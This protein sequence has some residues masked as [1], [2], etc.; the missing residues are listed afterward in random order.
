MR[1]YYVKMNG[2]IERFSSLKDAKDFAK[3]LDILDENG[4]KVNDCITV[5]ELRKILHMYNPDLMIKFDG[6]LRIEDI[7]YN[8]GILEIKFKGK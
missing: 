1:Y 2:M 7:V 4:V 6:D 3:D 5:G 8:D